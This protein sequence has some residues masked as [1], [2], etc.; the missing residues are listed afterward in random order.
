MTAREYARGVRSG[1]IVQGPHVRDSCER[2]ERDLAAAVPPGTPGGYWYDDDE[3]ERVALFFREQL[4]LLT[5]KYAGEPFELEPMWRFVIGNLM[6]WKTLDE[7]GEGV[8]RFTECW[9]ETGWKGSGKSPVFAGLALY[10]L[11]LDDEFGALVYW[12]AR[13][14][15]QANFGFKA[16]A[17]MVENSELLSKTLRVRVLG[18]SNPR[19]IEY[20]ET[21]SEMLKLAGGSKGKSGGVPSAVF[22][23]EIHEHDSSDLLDSLRSSV[24]GSRLQPLFVQVTNSGEGTVD[25]WVYE[26]HG[27]SCEVAARTIRDDQ[28]FSFV[29]ALDKGDDPWK[30]ESCWIK[31]VPTLPKLPG[32]REIRKEVGEAIAQPSKRAWT[33]RV[34]FCIWSDDSGNPMWSREA[35]LPCE[36]DELSPYELRRGRPCYIGID[37][38]VRRDLTCAAV[39]WDMGD[40]LEAEAFPWI[41]EGSL[42]W[43]RK[44]V[45]KGIDGWIEDGHIATVP[46]PVMNFD[47]VAEWINGMAERYDDIRCISYDKAYI[48][49]L[50]QALSDKGAPVEIAENCVV[51]DI[52]PGVIPMISYPQGNQL[53]V[54]ARHKDAIQVNMHTGIQSLSEDMLTGRLKAKRNLPLRW[55]VL[56]AAGQSDE[57][58]N[59]FLA[60]ASKAKID[61]AV[62]LVM[63]V[64]TARAWREAEPDPIVIYDV[65]G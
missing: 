28:H 59:T 31:A 3:E 51:K 26:R 22:A 45:S 23:D 36:V 5:G 13:D 25:N 30:D 49:A 1:A 21:R 44:K 63:A 8:R 48:V 7:D 24:K 47:Y 17:A 12:V 55:S 32:M 41:P 62:A 16:A 37:L 39:V 42:E 4:V 58:A 33:A 2:F 60:K 65:N 53:P 46:G 29:C 57:R 38:A 15:K 40:H 52:A 35:W 14:S 64:G 9:V 27:Y 56:G 11:C 20:A 43:F 19:E 54:G 6:G 34:R 61:P 10:L 18:G 50:K